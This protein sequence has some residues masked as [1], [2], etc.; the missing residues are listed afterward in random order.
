MPMK[1]K[2]WKFGDNV[3]TDEI[4]PARYLNTSDPKELAA[5]VIEDAD[6]AFVKKMTRGDIIV[7]GENFGCGSSREH[8]PIAI[9]EAGISCVIA[10][11]F[12]RIF[13][14]NAINIGLAIIPAPE[15]VEGAK[16]GQILDVDLSAGTVA[17]LGSGRSYS[18]PAFPPELAGIIAEGGLLNYMKK[19]VKT[20]A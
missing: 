5:H 10:K 20:G 3:N 8:A 16:E 6:P 9:K 4:I 1:G 18:F 17:N 19:N 7:A 2:V 15:V 14:R 13:F 12:A 11:S